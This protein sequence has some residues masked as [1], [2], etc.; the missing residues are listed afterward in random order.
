VADDPSM[1]YGDKLAA[2]RRLADEYFETERYEEFCAR[3][4]SQVD[5]IVYDWVTSD[6][7][8]AL[9]RE[10]VR[11]TYPVHEHEKFLA[12]FGGLIDAWVRDHS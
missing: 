11:A 4:L 2:Y 12:H 5:E 9:L 8:R 6:E 7:F 3:H 1:S 10:T